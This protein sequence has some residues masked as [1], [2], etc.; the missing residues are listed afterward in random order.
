MVWR[1]LKNLGIKP[2]Y[3]PATPLLGIYPVETKIER[4]TCIPLFTA[5]L[6]I[7]LMQQFTNMDA[8]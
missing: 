4:D 5:A 6:F 8:N 1:F 2:P 7:I 3:D